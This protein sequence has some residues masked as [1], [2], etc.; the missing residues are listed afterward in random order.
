MNEDIPAIQ[1]REDIVRGS[2]SVKAQVLKSNIPVVIL[3]KKE[4]VRW[5]SHLS[6]VYDQFYHDVKGGKNLVQEIQAKSQVL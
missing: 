3:S 1:E 6:P 4:R 2:K 5:K